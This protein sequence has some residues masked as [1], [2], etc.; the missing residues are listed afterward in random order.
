MLD[1]LLADNDITFK[2]AD[3]PAPLQRALLDNYA[4]P[5][6]LGLTTQ[7]KVTAFFTAA[8]KKSDIAI[9][10]RYGSWNPRTG[11]C[12]ADR[13]RREHRDRRVTT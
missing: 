7:E 9:D 4:Y 12:R 2:I 11:V 13:L 8:L 6:A 10:P 5:V 1:K 3:L